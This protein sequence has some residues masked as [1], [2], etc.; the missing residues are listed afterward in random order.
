VMSVDDIAE[1]HAGPGQIRIRAAA[2]SVNPVD[3]KFRYGYMAEFTR[4]SSR[5]FRG[6]TLP[7]LWMSWATAWT[8]YLWVIGSSAHDAGRD[9]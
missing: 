2:A 6:M 1:P 8:A 3:W 7:G 5:R 4:C 9:R